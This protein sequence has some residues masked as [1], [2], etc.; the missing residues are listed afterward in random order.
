MNFQT[1]QKSS[2]ILKYKTKVQIVCKI[3]AKMSSDEIRKFIWVQFYFSP[4]NLFCINHLL[5][6]W[7]N[8]C[9]PGIVLGYLCEGIS[10][11]MP[12][13][14]HLV[15][16]FIMKLGHA[17]HP[18]KFMFLIPPKFVI[19]YFHLHTMNELMREY[20]SW[21]STYPYNSNTTLQN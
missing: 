3:C 11:N 9:K 2:Y 12:V 20:E 5:L 16:Q 1:N 13:N 6:C 10:L 14:H 18:A 17:F 19:V 7:A 8:S 4:W 15:V 21:K